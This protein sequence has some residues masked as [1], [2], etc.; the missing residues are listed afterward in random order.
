M[1]DATAHS[2]RFFGRTAGHGVKALKVAART[3]EAPF[4]TNR[5]TTNIALVLDGIDDCSQVLYGF[6]RQRITTLGLI[7]PNRQPALLQV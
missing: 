3:E 5:H 2:H 7:E 6:I 1:S 4:A